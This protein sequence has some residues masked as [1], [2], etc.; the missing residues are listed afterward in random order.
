MCPHDRRVDHRVFIVCILGQMLEEVLPHSPFGPATEPRMHHAKIAEPFRQVAPW[1]S[2]SIAIENSLYKKPII[3][4]RTSYRTL[5]P[6]QH[7]FDPLPLIV[8]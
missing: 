6:W 3:P 1:D 5:P 2:S 4:S 8:P 7:P